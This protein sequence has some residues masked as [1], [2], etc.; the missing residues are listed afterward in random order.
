MARADELMKTL[1]AGSAALALFVLSACAPQ[2]EAPSD[3]GVCWHMVSTKAGVK[4]YKL[5]DHQPDL[6][7][8]A[9]SLEAMRIHFLSLGGSSREVDG[10]YQGQFLF[11][12]QRGVFTSTQLNGTP[13]LALVHTDD[14]RLAMP[15][16]V[17]Q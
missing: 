3:R 15:G 14:G 8:C 6:E 11:L 4:F 12:D 10:A 9:A 16:A 13:Y 17:Q 2:V 7:H 5:S 1:V